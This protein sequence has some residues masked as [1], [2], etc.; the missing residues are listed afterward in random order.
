MAKSPITQAKDFLPNPGLGDNFYP[1]LVEMCKRV[2]IL[3]DDLLN[4][5][6]LESRLNPA[7]HN[8]QGHASGLIQF[9][10]STL[11]KLGFPGTHEDLRRMTGE[12]QLPWV[13]KY[14][15]QFG[16]NFK[17]ATHYYVANFFPLALSLP[18]V[19][20][21]DMSTV[22]IEKNPEVKPGTEYSQKYAG[23]KITAKYETKVYEVNAG[24]D[25]DHDGKITLGDLQKRLAGVASSKDFK[26]KLSQLHEQTGH[27]PIQQEQ[28]KSKNKGYEQLMAE[29]NKP[30]IFDLL[31][32]NPTA[33]NISS[34][35]KATDQIDD[36]INKTLSLIKGAEKQNSELYK[37]YLPNNNIVLEIKA[38]NFVNAI[39]FSRILKSVFKEELFVKAN[40]CTDNVNNVELEISL[41]GPTDECLNA[42][43]NLTENTIK[44][45]KYAVKKIG[46]IDI[47]V[48]FNIN[49]KS[50]Y[51]PITWKVADINYRKFLLK[52]ND[53]S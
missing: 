24:L 47:D 44:S 45:F 5:M 22:I 8:P 49:K 2:N 18:G 20:N 46:N 34:T 10:P 42:I 13:E 41:A 32:G 48:N 39:E 12:E 11:K 6:M 52:F 35:Q 51:Q 26:N 37:K 16:G 50:C 4:V 1:K 19:R 17:S 15:K 25:A 31:S 23:S 36:M 40:I 53:V 14:I 7:A 30:N 3:P 21:N 38:D 28:D 27:T 33:S 9:M 43:F 29:N